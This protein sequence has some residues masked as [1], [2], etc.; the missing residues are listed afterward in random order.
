MGSLLEGQHALLSKLLTIV[1]LATTTLTLAEEQGKVNDPAWGKPLHRESTMVAVDWQSTTSEIQNKQALQSVAKPIV[2]EPVQHKVYQSPSVY[3]D[4]PRNQPSANPLF[5]GFKQAGQNLSQ[6]TGQTLRDLG[7]GTK[8]VAQ[9]L[10][11]GT[12]NTIGAGAK[13]IDNTVDNTF[14][15]GNQEYFNQRTQ[16]ENPNGIANQST[17]T[18]RPDLSPPPMN[19]QT[20]AYDDMNNQGFAT[21][22]SSNGQFN[23][24]AANDNNQQ[25]NQQQFTQQDYAQ[26]QYNQ[27]QNEVPAVPRRPLDTGISTSFGNRQSNPNYDDSNMATVQNQQPNNNYANNGYANNGNNNQSYSNQNPYQNNASPNYQNSNPNYNPNPNLITPPGVDQYA[28]GTSQL[29]AWTTPSFNDVSGP[30]LQETG[31]P[32]TPPN[33]SWPSQNPQQADVSVTGW[34]GSS[35]PSQVNNPPNNRQV[36]QNTEGQN[37][38]INPSNNSQL[39]WILAGFSLFGN[40]YG[41]TALLE[42]RNK[43]RA[44]LRRNPVN[45][46][47]G[48]L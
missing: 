1:L 5:D 35:T 36:A 19:R 10:Y 6:A 4:S 42:M 14:N 11:E 2:N 13:A 41:W 30:T 27:Q 28:G 40:V 22:Q 20:A 3:L 37:G 34:G 48:G 21:T 23:N 33:N 26:Q 39:L 32:V 17:P 24:S 44:S 7:T 45:L 15:M 47:D 18:I 25:Y 31:R 12:A 46:R 9:G 43:Y 16:Q 29:P 38:P 8:N